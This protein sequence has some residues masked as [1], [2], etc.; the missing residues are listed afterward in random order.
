MFVLLVELET[1][2]GRISE[3]ENVLRCLV[4]SA[5]NEPGILFYSVQRPLDDP[6]K[7]ILYEL[8][9]DKSAWETH[10]EHDLVK[11]K[12]KCFDALLSSPPKLIFCDAISNTL[13]VN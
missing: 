3:L 5:E 13:I 2:Q 12:L 4:E 10:L 9:V 7:F 1:D 6:N 11:R 8:Y